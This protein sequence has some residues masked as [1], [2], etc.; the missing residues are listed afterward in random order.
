MALPTLRKP[1]TTFSPL[2]SVLRSRN[3]LNKPKIP[4]FGQNPTIILA[5][6]QDGRRRNGNPSAAVS[7]VSSGVGWGIVVGDGV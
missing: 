6:G 2:T 5:G 1:P 3:V 7:R 4:Q